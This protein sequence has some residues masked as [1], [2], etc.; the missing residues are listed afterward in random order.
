MVSR[1]KLD[2]GLQE[3]D[4]DSLARKQPDARLRLRLLGLPPI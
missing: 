3:F 1:D 4:F 2:E